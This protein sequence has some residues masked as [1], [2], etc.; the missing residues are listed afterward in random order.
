MAAGT[1]IRTYYQGQ[2]H[3]EDLAVIR[4]GD[5]AAWLASMVFDGARYVNGVAPDLM[6]HCERVNNSARAMM[7]EPSHSA[8]DIHD[9]A[10]EGISAYPRDTPL[11]IRPMYWGIDN[12]HMAILN[13]PAVGFCICLEVMPMAAPEASVRLTRTRFHRPT[14]ETA[15]AN[16]KAGCLYPNSAR[17][18]AEARTKGYDN[19]I[20]ADPW[21]NVAETAVSNIF[22]AKDGEVFTPKPNGTFLNG[23]TRQRHIKNL[24]ADGI[25]VHE[26]TLSFEDFHNADEVFKTGN[27]Q[28]ITP[29]REF[30]GTSYEIGPLALRARKLYWDWAHS[31][32]QASAA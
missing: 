5:H 27:L 1:D 14:L 23:I 7:L 29:V 8:Q 32:G 24:R 3:N 12:I 4:A 10:W 30:D 18:L 26:A 28:K 22:M 15:V 31:A 9:I 2:W 21:G 17:M 11:Y 16:A 6:A 20:A 19:V 25:K 13:G